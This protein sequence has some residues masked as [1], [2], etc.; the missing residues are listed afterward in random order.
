LPVSVHTEARSQRRSAHQP[1]AQPG[2]PTKPRLL[3]F[4]LPLERADR[5]AEKAL[6]QVLHRRRNQKTFVIHRIDASQRKDLAERFRVTD[7]PAILVIAD[8]RVRARV[9]QPKDSDTI[10]HQLEPWLR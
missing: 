6:T 3:F 7:T 8:G 1:S 5:R 9:A 10:R 4:Y 2:S